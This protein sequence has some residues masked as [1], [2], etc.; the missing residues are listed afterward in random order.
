MSRFP[1]L[2]VGVL[3]WPCA[4]A[5]QDPLPTDVL[6]GSVAL[7]DGRPAAHVALELRQR[8]AEG[9]NCLD[10][11]YAHATRLVQKLVTGKTGTFAVQVPRGVPFELWL[12]DGE[13]APIVRHQVFGGEDVA[14]QL[15]APATL[16][17]V[18]KNE[19]GTPAAGGTLD[20][21]DAQRARFLGGTIDAQGQYHGDRLP[22][23]ALTLSI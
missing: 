3:A 9:F 21:W 11:P 19:D 6:R 10:L 12:D 7:P 8:D 17:V 14:V 1:V 4:A 23:G 5:A 20:C 16:A 15:T 2:L 18:L 22:V 13:H